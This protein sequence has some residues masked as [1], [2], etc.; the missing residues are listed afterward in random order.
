MGSD[1]LTQVRVTNTEARVKQPVDFLRH[2]SILV[3][4]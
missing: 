1:D 3:S 2:V 4:S